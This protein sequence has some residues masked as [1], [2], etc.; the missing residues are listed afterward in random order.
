MC[1]TSTRKG[2][3]PLPTP[4]T[5]VRTVNLLRSMRGARSVKQTIECDPYIREECG[6][7]S[8]AGKSRQEKTEGAVGM[9]L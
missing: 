8:S 5:E 3:L 6:R 1:W 7:S 9:M 2:S 4:S